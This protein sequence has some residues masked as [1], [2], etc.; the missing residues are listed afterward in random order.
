MHFFQ[1]SSQALYL[2]FR[3]RKLILSIDQARCLLFQLLL[4]LLESLTF[5]TGEGSRRRLRLRG[6]GLVNCEGRAAV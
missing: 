6:L 5:L 1:L 3:H 2:S 4:Y